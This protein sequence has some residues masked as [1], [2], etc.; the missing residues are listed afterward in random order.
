MSLAPQA[1]VGTSPGARYFFPHSEEDLSCKNRYRVVI[2]VKRDHQVA[3]WFAWILVDPRLDGAAPAIV[4]NMTI[5][6]RKGR[7][8]QFHQESLGLIITNNPV[9]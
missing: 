8:H 5:D 9:R 6:F 3:S 4:P 7:I 1:R 2:Y